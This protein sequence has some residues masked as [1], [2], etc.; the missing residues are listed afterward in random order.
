[1]RVNLSYRIS[2]LNVQVKANSEQTLTVTLVAERGVEKSEREVLVTVTVEMLRVLHSQSASVV[3]GESSR[4]FYQLEASGGAGGRNYTIVGSGGDVERSNGGF[5]DRYEE[6]VGDFHYPDGGNM[7]VFSLDDEGNLWAAG[8]AAAGPYLLAVE[9]SDNGFQVQRQTV[10]V[11]VNIQAAVQVSVRSI[12]H[13]LRINTK[14]IVGTVGIVGLLPDANAGDPGIGVV[15]VPFGTN[16]PHVDFVGGIAIINRDGIWELEYDR[17]GDDSGLDGDVLPL[18]KHTLSIDAGGNDV[19]AGFDFE[20]VPKIFVKRYERA[21][22]EGVVVIEEIET[23]EDTH[24]W[25]IPGVLS[26]LQA[27]QLEQSVGGS[28]RF[29]YTVSIYVEQQR[30]NGQLYQLIRAESKPSKLDAAA[31]GAIHLVDEYKKEGVFVVSAPY[32]AGIW[33]VVIFRTFAGGAIGE[34]K[35]TA[36]IRFSGGNLAVQPLYDGDLSVGVEDFDKYSFPLT[37]SASGVL[38][39]VTTTGGDV[40]A[41]EDYQVVLV[42]NTNDKLNTEVVPYVSVSAESGEVMLLVDMLPE[43]FNEGSRTLAI[44]RFAGDDESVRVVRIELSLDLPLMASGVSAPLTV[45]GG[46]GALLHEFEAFG[47]GDKTYELSGTGAEGFSVLGGSLSLLADTLGGSYTLT[48]KVSDA[49]ESLTFELT[50]LVVLPLSFKSPGVLTVV[51]NEREDDFYGFE[52]SGGYGEKTYSYAPTLGFAVG[53]DSDLLSYDGVG[54]AVGEVI[55]TVV[56]DDESELTP[57]EELLLTVELVAAL[58][59]ELS[60]GARDGVYSFVNFKGVVS[61]VELSGVGGIPPYTFMLL[62]N[63][64]FGIDEDGENFRITAE[65]A[66]TGAAEAVWVLEDSDTERTPAVTGTVRVNIRDQLDFANNKPVVNVTVGVKLDGVVYTAKAQQD[67][68]AGYMQIGRH[69]SFTVD[70]SSAEVGAVVSMISPLSEAMTATLTIRVTD[71]G[72]NADVDFG[73]AGI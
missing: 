27:G 1:M 65:F 11:A 31:G 55:L 13:N 39:T 49:E 10:S 51:V 8:S 23:E 54:G 63:D 17:K 9:V 12:P 42:S 6:N 47:G 21:A 67:D 64:N 44:K 38:L 7:T 2:L 15:E 52:V 16:A 50:V 48:A 5:F 26:S 14:Y 71:K 24:T 36:T 40:G 57:S 22:Y 56:V 62:A 58:S 28:D 41:Y 70:V 61:G 45:L 73:S 19:N 34:N 37:A 25:H 66:N 30:D 60:E 20:G 69:P 35:V 46:E 33:E 3:Y 72:V 18:G 4:A 53:S 59:A 29:H 43:D 32:Y 68:N